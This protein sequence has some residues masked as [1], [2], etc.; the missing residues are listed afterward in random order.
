MGCLFSY[1]TR[2]DKTNYHPLVEENLNDKL[3]EFTQSYFLTESLQE[4]PINLMRIPSINSSLIGSSIDSTLID[5]FNENLKPGNYQKLRDTNYII[6][7]SKN[8]IY[9]LVYTIGNKKD[10]KFKMINS[11]EKLEDIIKIY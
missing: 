1:F 7:Y 2:R 4:S 11:S 10:P 9:S 6:Y 3:E 5:T 8:C